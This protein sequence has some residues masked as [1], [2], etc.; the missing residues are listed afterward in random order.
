[1][2]PFLKRAIIHVKVQSLPFLLS[3]AVHK[4]KWYEAWGYDVVV[5]GAGVLARIYLIKPYRQNY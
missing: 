4:E 3:P 1:M 2:V 5:V